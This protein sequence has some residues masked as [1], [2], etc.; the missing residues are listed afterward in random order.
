LG[1]DKIKTL[2]DYD[3]KNKIVWAIFLIILTSAI[4]IPSVGIQSKN[5]RGAAFGM[6]VNTFIKNAVL[7]FLVF[8]ICYYVFI[9]QIRKLKNS[10][11]KGSLFILQGL[12]ILFFAFCIV[13]NSG[14][15]LSSEAALLSIFKS[16]TYNFVYI[17]PT[18]NFIIA[19]T[20]FVRDRKTISKT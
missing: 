4:I 8:P 6:E 12:G 10:Y 3:S 1:N 5:I 14:I 15:D 16:D 18:L 17:I 7:L 11:F 2:E 19:L 9:R 20:Y 13:D